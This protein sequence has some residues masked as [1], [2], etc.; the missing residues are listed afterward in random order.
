MASMLA[1][2]L[3]LPDFYLLHCRLDSTRV[4]PSYIRTWE[5]IQIGIGEQIRGIV[6]VL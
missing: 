6:R 4:D 3:L 5:V 1:S 2:T